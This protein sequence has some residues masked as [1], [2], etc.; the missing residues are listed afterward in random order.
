M[1][2]SRFISI[3]SLF[4]AFLSVSAPVFALEEGLRPAPEI[5]TGVSAVDSVRGTS[6]M[7]V[8][9]HPEATKAA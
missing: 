4:L 5:A 7:A 9:A 2:N 8:T 6:M 1:I 3:F